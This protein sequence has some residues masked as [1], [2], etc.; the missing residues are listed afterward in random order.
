MP[1]SSCSSSLTLHPELKSSFH[2]GKECHTVYFRA[3]SVIFTSVTYRLDHVTRNALAPRNNVIL[4]PCKQSLFFVFSSKEE[5]RR[6]WRIQ[7][8]GPPPPLFL[9][10]TEARR[11]EKT[12]LRP[13]PPSP[14]PTYLKVWI[15]HWESLPESR[16]DFEVANFWTSQSCFLSSNLFSEC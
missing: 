16:Q 5:K 2:G 7:G 11:A 10:K 4:T 14:S 15:R 6:Q 1:N 9:D 3:L 13:P 8:R 12:F